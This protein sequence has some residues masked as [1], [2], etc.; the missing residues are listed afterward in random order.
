MDG[1]TWSAWTADG[2]TVDIPF[3]T[4][5]KISVNNLVLPDSASLNYIRYRVTETGG[6][7]SISAFYLIRVDA[8]P[9][10]APEGLV[11]SPAAWTNAASFT[12][13]WTNPADVAGIA[14]AWYKLD[15][16]PTS[17]TDGTYVATQ[18]NIP[19]LI[20]GERGAGDGAHAVYV[21]LRD[22]LGRADPKTA[23]MTTLYWDTTAPDPPT[24]MSGS[25]ARQWTNVNRFSESWRNPFDLSGIVG[26]Y[27]KLNSPPESA[28]DGTFVKTV[29]TITDISVPRDGRNDIWVWLV[30]AA[31]NVDP[32]AVQSHAEVFWY[33]STPPASSAVMTPNLPATG[34][35]TSS[36]S[37]SFSA[38]DLPLDAARPPVVEYQLDSAA[39]VVAPPV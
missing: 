16:A 3:S 4:T 21:W 32:T 17:P 14:G 30:D 39:W 7:E 6:A 38:T 1:G 34:W 19:E 24:W 36:I 31:G 18:G 23:A 12:V 25:P 2:L 9:P 10:A 29:N 11:A 22:T 27:Y 8:T 26:A 13:S 15:T 20:P 5:H 33:D 35:Y 37:M 28:T